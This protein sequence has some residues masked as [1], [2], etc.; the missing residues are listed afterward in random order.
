MGR[1]PGVAVSSGSLYSFRVRAIVM[2]ACAAQGC[3]TELHLCNMAACVAGEMMGI[4]FRYPYS[5]GTAVHACP[6]AAQS[7]A[8][9]DRCI[10]RYMPETLWSQAR[11][12]ASRRRLRNLSGP[13]LLRQAGEDACSGEG[14]VTRGEQPRDCGRLEMLLLIGGNWLKESRLSCLE[15]READVDELL[16]VQAAVPVLAGGQRLG[17]QHARGVGRLPDAPLVHPPRDLLKM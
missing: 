17:K 12:A 6:E 4:S 13:R 2:R 11:T 9:S 15:A 8:A 16:G 7:A 1:K 3:R 10:S 14:R 5:L